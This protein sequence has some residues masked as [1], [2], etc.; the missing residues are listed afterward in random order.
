VT[1]DDLVRYVRRNVNPA[2][3]AWF[4]DRAKL[5]ADGKLQTPHMLGSLVEVPV[6]ADLGKGGTNFTVRFL[7]PGVFSS[8][9]FRALVCVAARCW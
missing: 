8:V 7:I 6:L 9:A 4:P 1:W 5:K 2:A 3:Q